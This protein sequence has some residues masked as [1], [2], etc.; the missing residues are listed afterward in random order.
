MTF[1]RLSSAQFEPKTRHEATCSP[2]HRLRFT[3]H[4]PT[5]SRCATMCLV[6][7]KNCLAGRIQHGSW[8]ATGERGSRSQ[9]MYRCCILS[10]SS[11]I[12]T[13]APPPSPCRMRAN[14]FWVTGMLS[15]SQNNLTGASFAA[16]SLL[17]APS[18]A[19]SARAHAMDREPRQSRSLKASCRGFA[20]WSTGSPM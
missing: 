16:S 2:Q 18:R 14:V 11:S 15:W 8:L 10:S 5:I 9:D 13:V 4:S 3:V 17:L 7:Q 19:C 1:R 20:C 6:D 12:R